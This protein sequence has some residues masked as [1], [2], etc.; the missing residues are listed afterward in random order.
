MNQSTESKDQFNREL[1]AE[2][3]RFREILPNMTNADMIK[4]FHAQYPEYSLLDIEKVFRFRFVDHAIL[5]SFRSFIED[6][7]IGQV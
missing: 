5:S 7:K 6:M 1:L 2:K 3:A 4:T